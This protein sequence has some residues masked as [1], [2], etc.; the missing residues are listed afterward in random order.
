MRPKAASP[1]FDRPGL[2][3]SGQ[4]LEALMKLAGMRSRHFLVLSHSIF[5]KERKDPRFKE[6]GTPT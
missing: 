5:A 1:R 3:D 6:A 2:S 4:T